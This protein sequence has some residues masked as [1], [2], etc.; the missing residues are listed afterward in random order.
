M[1]AEEIERFSRNEI[2]AIV[3]APRGCGARVVKLELARHPA[4]IKTV[5]ESDQQQKTYGQ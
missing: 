5:P 4:S 3:Y 2:D 1:L